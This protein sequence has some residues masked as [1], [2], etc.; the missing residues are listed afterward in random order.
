MEMLSGELNLRLSQV[1]DT[2]MII[3]RVQ[4]SRAIKSAINDRVIPEIQNA[5]GTLSSGEKDTESGSS[6]YNQEDREGSNGLKTTITKKDSRSA[7]K[8]RDT[9]YL[10][11][12]KYGNPYSYKLGRMS[13]KY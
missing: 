9:E 2:L 13:S 6:P 12:Y 8:L 3:L 10:S 7:F 5:M 11:P 4:I 1:R